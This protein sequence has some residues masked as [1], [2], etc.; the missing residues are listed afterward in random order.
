M[1]VRAARITSTSVSISIVSIILSFPFL[2]SI[3]QTILGGPDSLR[4]V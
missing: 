4:T 3:H 2:E 1:Y